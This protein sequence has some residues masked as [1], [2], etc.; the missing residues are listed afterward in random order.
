MFAFSCTQILPPHFRHKQARTSSLSCLGAAA[1]ETS[2]LFMK[3]MLDSCILQQR[4]SIYK[5]WTWESNL[6]CML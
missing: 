5:N 3:L 2:Y 1:S 6:Y 4:I